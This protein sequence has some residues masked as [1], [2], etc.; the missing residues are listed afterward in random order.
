MR[1]WALLQGRDQFRHAVKN[2][3]AQAV[4]RQNTEE[5]LDHIQERARK[6]L[7]RLKKA[8]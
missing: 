6:K 5:T 8:R 2:A 1:K 7:N 4:D 3:S